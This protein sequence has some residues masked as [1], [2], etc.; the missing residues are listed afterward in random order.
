LDLVALV[1][2]K[3]IALLPCFCLVQIHDEHNRPIGTR[4]SGLSRASGFENVSNEPAFS[5]P[6]TPEKKCYA[7]FFCKF[8]DRSDVY[9]SRLM[10]IVRRVALRIYWVAPKASHVERHAAFYQPV[11]GNIQQRFFE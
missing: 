2:I 11:I 10:I 3:R 7:V 4:L 5:G 8:Y 9:I 1:A 6:A